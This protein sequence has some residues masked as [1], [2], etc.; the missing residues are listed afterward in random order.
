[1]M[2]VD[3]SV[4]VAYYCPEPISDQVEKMILR[5]SDPAISS[6]T[7]IELA[8]AVARKVRERGLSKEDGNR[9]LN[10]FRHHQNQRVFHMIPI[11]PAH[12]RQAF[13]W[14]CDFSTA[15]RTLDALHLAVAAG[16]DL[17][18]VTAD[19]QIARSGEKIG[20]K[21]ALIEAGAPT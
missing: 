14:M 8:S 15:L 21:I 13:H 3:T 12:F 4:L 11:E 6:L 18:M 19:K 16:D 17:E 9:V 2:Y 5:G 1:M 20:L 10:Q 7:E